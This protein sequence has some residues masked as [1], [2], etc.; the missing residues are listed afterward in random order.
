M[1][2]SC[3]G[4]VSNVNNKPMFLYNIAQHA[5]RALKIN[6]KMYKTNDW[7][8][9]VCFL[10]ERKPPPPA[11]LLYMKPLSYSE[12]DSSKC[13]KKKKKAWN[14][15][16][17]AKRAVTVLVSWTPAQCLCDWNITGHTGWARPA[18]NYF[19]EW[20]PPAQGG[21]C[22]SWGLATLVGL[23]KLCCPCS[24]MRKVKLEWNQPMRPLLAPVAVNTHC[25][26]FPS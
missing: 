11:L 17:M 25:H 1:K 8:H 4:S 22:G 13:Q 7:W 18:W 26:I 14:K 16:F 12:S 2:A 20:F 24:V 5:Q 19:Y 6:N 3:W 21:T 10:G 9:L 23:R 15:C